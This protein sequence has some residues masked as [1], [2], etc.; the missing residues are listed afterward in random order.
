MLAV[1]GAL[2]LAGCSGG[3]GGGYSTTQSGAPTVP[4]PVRNQLAAAG[5]GS[6]SDTSTIVRAKGPRLSVYSSA[7]QATPSSSLSNPNE[8]GAPRVLLVV[9]QL[10]GWYQVLLPVQPNGSK[11]WVKAADVTASKTGYRVNVSRGGHTV[12]VYNGKAVVLKA[13]VAI[14][15]S[16][17]PTPG[18]S[19]YITELLQPTNPDGAYGPYA[20]GL[21]GFS[22]T[23]ASFDGGAPQIGLHG[24]NQP[25]Y[26]GHDVSHGCI[27]M[28]NANIRALARILPLGT[29]VSIAA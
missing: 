26:I 29:P 5:L 15:T 11:G 12:T 27:R 28:S 6:G 9:S 2:V 3:G 22:T 4:A 20:F 1:L 18:G 25:Q 14:G 21:S 7:L 8:V 16:D 23:L 13:P 19:Y 10:P 17:T 24:T